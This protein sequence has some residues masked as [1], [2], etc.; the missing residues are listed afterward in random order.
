MT[1]GHNHQLHSIVQ[2][3]EQLEAAKADTTK[4][5]N[6][7]YAAAKAD[8]YDVRALRAVVRLRAW[9]RKALADHEAKVDAYTDALFAFE[10]TPLGRAMAPPVVGQPAEDAKRAG[11]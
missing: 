9:D 3:I 2:R 4:A 10:H 7:S 11:G 1:S 5:I 6:H 8:G